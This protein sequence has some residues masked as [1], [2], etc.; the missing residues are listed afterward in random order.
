MTEQQVAQHRAAGTLEQEVLSRCEQVASLLAGEPRTLKPEQRQAIAAVAAGRDS[1]ALLPTGHGKSFCYQLPALVLPGVSVV[2]SPLISLMHDQALGL[3]HTIGGAVRA[4]VASLP[5]SVS[6][7]GRTEVV[8]ALSGDTTHGI[9]LVYVSPERLSQSRFRQALTRGA[10]CGALARVAIDEAHTYVQWG[11]D[12]RP[13]S[14]APAR[15]CGS[16][17][18]TTPASS[19]FRR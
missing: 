4:L 14:A 6:R 8:E 3:N 1:L 16:C 10:A 5:E 15:C 13:T 2:V 19:R 17:A 9:K 11:E 12:F 7:A 18:A